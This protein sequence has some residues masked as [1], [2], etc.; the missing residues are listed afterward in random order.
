MV[1]DLQWT[2]TLQVCIWRQATLPQVPFC[3]LCL[4]DNPQN[5]SEKYNKPEACPQTYS[6]ALVKRQQHLLGVSG[7]QTNTGP[8]LML[9]APVKPLSSAGVLAASPISSLKEGN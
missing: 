1:P 7:A 3:W 9:A 5:S 6:P 2:A 4:V 8:R